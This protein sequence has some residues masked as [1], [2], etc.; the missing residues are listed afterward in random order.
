MAIA[1]P[2][3]FDQSGL[4][5]HDLIPVV[6]FSLHSVPDLPQR[7]EGAELLQRTLLEGPSHG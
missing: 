2:L 1:W 5:K 6:S 7:F 4:V 3:T